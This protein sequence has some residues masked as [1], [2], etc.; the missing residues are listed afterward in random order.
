MQTLEVLWGNNSYIF[1]LYSGV[2]KHF[3][4]RVMEYVIL[5]EF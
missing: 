5:L 3:L 1:I 2:G 4:W